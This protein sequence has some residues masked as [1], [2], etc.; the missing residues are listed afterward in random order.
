MDLHKLY[1]IFFDSSG[2]KVYIFLLD[3]IKKFICI[4][5]MTHKKHSMHVYKICAY[6]LSTFGKKLQKNW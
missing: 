3:F 4:I 2:M 6:K 5:I 1:T